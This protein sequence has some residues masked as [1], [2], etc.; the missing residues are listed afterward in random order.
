MQPISLETMIS[1]LFAHAKVQREIFQIEGK[2]IVSRALALYKEFVSQRGGAWA[3]KAI[4]EH[5][6]P[7]LTKMRTKEG[8]FFPC[9]ISLF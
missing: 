2:K 8:D 6:E 4:Y 1:Q 5:F 3:F 7:C 9:H